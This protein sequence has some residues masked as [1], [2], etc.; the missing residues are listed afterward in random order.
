MVENIK[1]GVFN[2]SFRA[3]LGK[4]TAL[5]EKNIALWLNAKDYTLW[6]KI[7]DKT[8]TALMRLLLPEFKLFKSSYSYGSF[9]AKA[10]HRANNFAECVRFLENLE[11]KKLIS[12]SIDDENLALT[13]VLERIERE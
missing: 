12:K 5:A 6:F 2:V 1:V 3:K 7:Y 13:C 9:Y 11:L 4:R 8:L 10:E